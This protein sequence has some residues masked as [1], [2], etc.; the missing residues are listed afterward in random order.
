MSDFQD[1]G[2]DNAGIPRRSFLA[3]LG[4]AAVTGC[5]AINPMKDKNP[6]A[7]NWNNTPPPPASIRSADGIDTRLLQ[8]L[9]TLQ[10]HD[11]VPEFVMCPPKK[12]HP[13]N[14][15]ADMDH[16]RWL[17]KT[18]ETLGGRVIPMEGGQPNTGYGEVWTRDPVLSFPGEKVFFMGTY[19]AHGPFDKSRDIGE[20]AKVLAKKLETLGF[21]KYVLPHPSIDGGEVIVDTKRRTVFIGYDG[22]INSGR[23]AH[24]W[25]TARAMEEVTGYRIV[26]VQRDRGTTQLAKDADFYHLDCG[27]GK[28]PGGE[29]LVSESAVTPESMRDLKAVLKNDLI[30][31]HDKDQGTSLGKN[32]MG[33]AYNFI[34][35]GR[36]L[37]MPFCNRELET[38]LTRDHGY[39]VVTPE[40][41]GLPTGCWKFSNGSIHCA[42]QQ[43]AEKPDFAH[44]ESSKANIMAELSRQRIF[45]GSGMDVEKGAR[46]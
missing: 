14:N 4:A 3:A 35:V 39:K 6:P 18:I 15:K 44:P 29:Y 46:R 13:F 20:E 28:L 41:L 45:L 1:N 33:M 26:P 43:I 23:N 25:K 10:P 27:M 16:W 37:I 21:K 36:T 9:K 24:R 11:S 42:T 38:Q 32:A 12:L 22:D 30:V 2:D 8:S 17:T 31:V 19:E 40:K 5:R 7:G 34:G